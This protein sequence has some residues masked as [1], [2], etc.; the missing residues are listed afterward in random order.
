MIGLHDWSD[1]I[2]SYGLFRKDKTGGCKT[3]FTL[4][5]REQLECM[6]LCLGTDN[7]SVGSHG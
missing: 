3:R 5:F 7:K 4:C 6:E 1:K 2:E